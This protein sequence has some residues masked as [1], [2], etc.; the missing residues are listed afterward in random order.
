[1]ETGHCK[2]FMES[3]DV[4][5]TMDLSLLRSYDELHRKLAD[6]FGIEKS[7][8]LSRVLYC[9]SVGAIKHIGDE[10]FSDFTRT[11]KRLT[12]LM[13]SGSNNVGV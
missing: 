3:E 4:G 1:M 10:P 9:D 11:A 8:M 5:R 2:V 7:E 6:M 13:D 12:I